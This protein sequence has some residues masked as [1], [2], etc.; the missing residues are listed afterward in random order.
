MVGEAAVEAST[1]GVV[2]GGGDRWDAAMISDDGS[3]GWEPRSRSRGE[4]Q[5]RDEVGNGEMREPRSRSRGERQ[6]RDEVG[7]GEMLREGRL[8]VESKSFGFQVLGF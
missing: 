8:R 6:S 2:R 1:V 7:N 5:S 4:R 3:Q